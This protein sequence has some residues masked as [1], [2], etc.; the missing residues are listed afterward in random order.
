MGQL[1]CPF[2]AYKLFKF[3]ENK[4]INLLRKEAVMSRRKRKNRVVRL[5]EKDYNNYI[6]SLKEEKPVTPIKTIKDKMDDTGA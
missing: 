1:P 3:G 6:M 5:T 2:F 4:V